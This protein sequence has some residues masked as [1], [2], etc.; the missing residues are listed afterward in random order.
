[1]FVLSFLFAMCLPALLLPFASGVWLYP[2]TDSTVRLETV[3][4]TRTLEAEGLRS[5]PL[6]NIPGRVWGIT[7][8]LVRDRTGRGVLV[9]DSG[10]WHGEE[11]SML[12]GMLTVIAWGI[13][14]ALMLVA[15][16]ELAF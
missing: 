15:L 16:M 8:M 1:M 11:G 7:V 3:L 10:L 13:F 5:W 14:S 9:M 2:R 4:G 6:F 12:V